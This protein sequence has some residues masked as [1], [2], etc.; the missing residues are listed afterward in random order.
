ME[1]Y[2]NRLTNPDNDE[3]YS[4]FKLLWTITT[5]GSGWRIYCDLQL[6]AFVSKEALVWLAVELSPVSCSSL[7]RE[8]STLDAQS[9]T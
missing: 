8:K 2:H 3:Q 1:Y 9:I 7:T 5:S 6:R 4:V